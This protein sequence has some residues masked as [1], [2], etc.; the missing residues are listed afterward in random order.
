MQRSV[1]HGKTLKNNDLLIL[2]APKA[3]K[4]LQDQ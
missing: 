3:A 2:L 4:P 1:G